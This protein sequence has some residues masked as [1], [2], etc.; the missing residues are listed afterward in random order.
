[1]IVDGDPP[2]LIAGDVSYR[3]DLM[4]DGKVDGVAPDEGQARETL[5]RTREYVR[6]TGAVYVPTHDP[7]SADRLATATATSREAGR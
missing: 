2:V 7:A 4:L 6:S 3:L 5:A 1:M